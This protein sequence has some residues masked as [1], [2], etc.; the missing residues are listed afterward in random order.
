MKVFKYL[1]VICSFV[2]A[3]CGCGHKDGEHIP[4][5]TV[6]CV[7]VNKDKDIVY[8][9]VTHMTHVEYNVKVL[10]PNTNKTVILD[11]E[12]IYNDY[13]VGDTILKV[14]HYCPYHYYEL[15]P[16]KELDKHVKIDNNLMY[17]SVFHVIL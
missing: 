1:L 17:Q 9:I 8:D 16:S 5:D 12:N 2:L 3:S 4:N 7:I 11:R 10:D 13:E 6:K 15:A 14:V